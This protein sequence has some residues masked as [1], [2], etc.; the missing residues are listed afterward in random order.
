MVV[1][2]V[3]ERRLGYAGDGGV[4]CTAAATARIHTRPQEGGGLT[5]KSGHLHLGVGFGGRTELQ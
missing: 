2:V 1:G 3:G 5:E 4:W